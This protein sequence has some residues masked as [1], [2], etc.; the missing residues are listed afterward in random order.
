MIWILGV[1]VSP[2]VLVVWYARRRR[3]GVTRRAMRRWGTMFERGG[4]KL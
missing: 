2:W 3:A 1:M 4:L